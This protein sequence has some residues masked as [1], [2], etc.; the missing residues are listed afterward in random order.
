MLYSTPSS[1]QP[2]PDMALRDRVL[3]MSQRG[4]LPDISHQG[5]LFGEYSSPE[6]LSPSAACDTTMVS[7]P[8]YSS[9]AFGGQLSARS[10]TANKG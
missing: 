1:Q 3:D 9:T 5:E 4:G 8:C 6:T 7:S 10:G 2:L